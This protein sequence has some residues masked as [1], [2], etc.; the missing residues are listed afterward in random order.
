MYR[1]VKLNLN[2]RT[3]YLMEV[4]WLYALATLTRYALDWKLRVPESKCVWWPWENSQKLPGIEPQLS[5]P[6]LITCCYPGSWGGLGK[7]SNP[8]L[9]KHGK[10]Q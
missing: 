3:R 10:T 4:S 6:Q 5:S 8:K 7:H 9:P 2:G 1:D